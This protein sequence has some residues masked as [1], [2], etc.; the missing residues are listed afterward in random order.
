MRFL[1]VENWLNA[2]GNSK[3]KSVVYTVLEFSTENPPKLSDL[4]FEKKK[5]LLEEIG[6]DPQAGRFRQ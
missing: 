3:F 6:D 2:T 5:E 4:V 1:E